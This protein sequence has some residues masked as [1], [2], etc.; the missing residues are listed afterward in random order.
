MELMTV[1]GLTAACCTTASF[2]PQV[3]HILKT[4]NVSG[5]SL[6]MYSIFTFGVALWMIY[7][8]LIKDISVFTANAITFILALTVLLLTLSHNRKLSGQKKSE[9]E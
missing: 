5:I 1:L 6:P 2:V 7:G 4:K 9:S 8:F 3:W